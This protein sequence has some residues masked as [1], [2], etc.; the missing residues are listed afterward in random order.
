LGNRN[1]Q[2]SLRHDRLGYQIKG[3]RL[4]RVMLFI[5]ALHAL[6]GII[7]WITEPI[8][9]PLAIVLLLGS[10]VALLVWFLRASK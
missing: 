2:N 10:P 4:M 1:Q 6:A 9:V 3:E 8:A 7:G 5:I